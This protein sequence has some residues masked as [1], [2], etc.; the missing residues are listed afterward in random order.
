MLPH[1]YRLVEPAGVCFVPLLTCC[2]CLCGTCRYIVV[3][4]SPLSLSLFYYYLK[5]EGY[6]HYTFSKNKPERRKADPPWIDD[7]LFQKHDARDNQYGADNSK[8]FR[9]LSEPLDPN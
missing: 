3:A 7:L 4:S 6:V 1:V 8:N 5:P 2:R 9:Q